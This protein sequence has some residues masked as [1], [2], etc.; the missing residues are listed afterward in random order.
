MASNTT[1]QEALDHLRPW[2]REHRAE[3]VAVVLYALCVGVLALA[4]PVAVQALVNTVAFATLLQ[5]LVVLAALLL[6]GLSLSALLKLLKTWTAE[7]LQRRM[8]V[9]TVARLAHRLPRATWGTVGAGEL[10]VHRFFDLFAIQKTAASLLLGGV[11]VLLMAVVGLLVLGFYHPLLLAFDVV[12]LCSLALIVFGLGRRGVATSIEESS[13]KY[14]MAAFLSEVSRDGVAFRDAGGRTYVEERVDALAKRWLD[15]RG[16]HFRIV[17]RQFAGG[18]TLQ[19]VSS[20][21]LLGLGGV[22]VLQRELTLGQLVAAE[23]IVSVLVSTLSELG[24]Y[25]ESYYDMVTSAY[26]LDG[27]LSLPTEPE[28]DGGESDELVAT[29]EPAL[30]EFTAVHLLR[31]NRQVL[32]G[33][34]LKLEPGARIQLVGPGESGKSSVVDLLFGTVEPDRGS[35]QLDGTDTRELSRAALRERVAVVREPEI[36]SGTPIDNVRLGRRDV[37]LARV[38]RLLD[39]LGLSEELARLPDGLDTDLGAPGARISAGQAFRLTL[40]R[41]LLREP[42]LLV[43]DT[44]LTALDARSLERVERVL[45][46]DGAPFTLLLVGDHEA[47]RAMCQRVVRIEDGKL[48]QKVRS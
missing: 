43:L 18:L 17:L 8:F 36:I 16:R 1:G 34:D 33:A 30:V 24:K 20:G 21:L 38:K 39:D 45:C 5:P 44:D 22:L 40:A 35:V 46:R 41:A 27:L 25:L 23:L 14:D 29:R 28:G 7:V 13:A 2:L 42:G 19:A 26:K 47:A 6:L 9:L 48:T 32:E 31:G 4:T 11:D 12:L 3:V 15:A 10:A 37:P